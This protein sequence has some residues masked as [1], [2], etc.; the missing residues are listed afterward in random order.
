MIPR[1]CLYCQTEFTAPKAEV[2][3]GGGI[4]CSRTCFSRHRKLTAK[5][6]VPN[7]ECTY[8]GA[9]LYRKP[10]MVKKSSHFFCNLTH[11]NLANC[12]PLFDYSSGATSGPGSNVRC[13]TCNKKTQGVE[14]CR[15]CKKAEVISAWLA[16]DI[17]VTR[18]KG[19]VK[20][21]K[22]FVKEHL[23][24]TRGDACEVCGFDEKAP[25]GRSIIQMDHIDGN[26]LNNAIDNLQ[27]LCPNHHAMTP[28]YG[29]LNK[30]GGRTHRQ[31]VV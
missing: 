19:K 4:F 6:L 3:R 31:K 24:N 16:G 5:P 10:S 12:D 28:T 11:Q 17:S 15:S 21:S 20:E 25:D 29:S 14:V 2:N 18:C 22:S 30:G 8:C 27:L 26:Y 1:I 23:V 9:P 13:K 7:V